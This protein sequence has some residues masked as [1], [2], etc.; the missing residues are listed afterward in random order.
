[1]QNTNFSTL[2]SRWR[3]FIKW[4]SVSPDG[5]VL[6]IHE[7]INPPIFSFLSHIFT[8]LL[9][10]ARIRVITYKAETYTRSLLLN[11]CFYDKMSS[12]LLCRGCYSEHLCHLHFP[13][14]GY[15]LGGNKQ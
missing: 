7:L 4:D 5:L 1:M 11:Q 8:V 15:G 6:S 14:R 12:Y 10:I 2:F 13:R 9:I 3:L